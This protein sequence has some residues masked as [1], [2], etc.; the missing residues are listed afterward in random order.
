VSDHQCS[1]RG[2]GLCIVCG[3]RVAEYGESE[4]N[5]TPSENASHKT[6]RNVWIGIGSLAVILLAFGWSCRGDSESSGSAD[7]ASDVAPSSDCVSVSAAM[8]DAVASGAQDRTG[9][10]PVAAAAVK[11]P[12]FSSV[13]FVAMEFSATGIDNQ[14]GVWATNSLTP[15]DG[16]ILSASSM[17]K[18]FTV[19]PD[20]AA[21]DAAI[22]AGDPGIRAAEACLR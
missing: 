14:V 13:Y 9:L 7:S 22:S 2:D 17:A 19:W 8:M 11:S 15:G 4:P 20:A 21:T 5:Q 3:S 10:M 16:L 12:D 1:N 18:E 6:S